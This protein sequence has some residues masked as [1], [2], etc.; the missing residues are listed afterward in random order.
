M[1]SSKKDKN[2]S[3]MFFVHFLH[4]FF[5]YPKEVSYSRVHPAGLIENGFNDGKNNNTITT[6]IVGTKGAK[7]M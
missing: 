1:L 6:F 5:L 2:F 4:S 3:E 7:L